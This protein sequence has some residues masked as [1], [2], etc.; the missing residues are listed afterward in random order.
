VFSFL[1][2]PASFFRFAGRPWS[3]ISYMFMHA[4][5]L[6]LLFNML[7]LYGFGVLFLSFFS[8]KHLRGLYILGGIFGGLLYMLCYNVF[9][10]FRL[11]VEHSSMVG[12]SASVLAVVIAVAY[13]EPDYSIRLMFL[14]NIRLKYIALVVVLS[15][16]LFITSGNAGGHIAHLGG[17]FTGFGFVVGLNKGVDITSWM[18]KFLDVILVLF[19]RTTWQHKRKPFMKM[20]QLHGEKT[21]KHK[22]AGNKKTYPPV[23]M[24][25]ILDKLKKSGYESLTTEEKK[26]LFDASRK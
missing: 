5:F 21:K 7:W 22:L 8:A 11:Q 19:N 1:E 20:Q 6:H 25:D 9:P 14:G 18:N 24:D 15:D 3:L 4:D 16:L 17:A 23:M 26:T 13:R 2:L 12:A 10:Y